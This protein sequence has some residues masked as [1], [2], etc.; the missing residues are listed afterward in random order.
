MCCLSVCHIVVLIAFFVVARARRYVCVC[1]AF[2]VGCA[3]LVKFFIVFF[4]VSLLFFFNGLEREHGERTHGQQTKNCRCAAFL[5][6][7]RDCCCWRSI[8]CENRRVYAALYLK[9]EVRQESAKSVWKQRLLIATRDASCL[10]CRRIAV[11]QAFAT[12][13]PRCAYINSRPP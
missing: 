5:D 8:E 12:C 1:T 7:A 11:F 10:R 4:S 3:V 9:S 2:G 6:T 13:F